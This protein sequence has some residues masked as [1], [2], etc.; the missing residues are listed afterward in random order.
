MNITKEE[1]QTQL[2][3]D[4]KK[5]TFNK[6][7]GTLREMICSLNPKH[8]PKKKE[9]KEDAKPKKENPDIVAVWDMDNKG[10]RSIILKSIVEIT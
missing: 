4:T 1:L 6:K 5:I 3:T 9:L 10:W 7:D 2:K 8:L